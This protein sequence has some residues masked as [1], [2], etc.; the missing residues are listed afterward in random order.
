MNA[1]KTLFAQLMD[2]VPWSTFTRL[3]T[4]YDGD[5]RVRS[6]SC[7]EQYRAMAFAQ[8]T[9][10]ESLRDIE[11][12][13]SAQATKLYAMGF[14]EPVRRSTLA[15]ANEA[16]N[17][18]I[19]AELAQR[20]I[21]QARKLYADEDLG[22]DLKN[23]VYAL[24][25]TTIDLCLSVFPWAHFR[26]TKSAVKMHTLL[27]L[28]GNI[29][30][31][32]HISDGKL[33]DV[34]ALDLL[35]PEPG[36]IYVMDRAYVDFARL[37]ALHQAGAF[38]VTRA[39]SNMDAR[40]VY[41]APSDRAAGIICDQTIAL[42]G[43]QTSRHYPEHL[44]RVRFKDPETGK[45]LV[46]LTNQR[47]LPAAT[48]CALY[49]SRWQVELFFKWIKQHLRIK[50]FYGTSENAVKTQ[51]WIAVSVYVLVAI[52]KKRLELDASL[53]TLLQI[54]SITLFE[55]MPILQALSQDQRTSEQPV[56]DNQLNLFAR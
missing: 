2:F 39:K 26:T 51:I 17:W 21:A 9:Y 52:V 49:K 44:R 54:L 20:L 53:Y 19:Y 27:D 55:K 13:L 33:H 7:G 36:A 23:S 40:R 10:R 14:R 8:L 43:V 32:I 11:T 35:M 22:L 1:G 24:D 48:I 38:F 56:V 28:R 15:D 34:H 5:I 29:P 47:T 41:S 6:L 45:S 3:V 4:R 37:H 25:S 16:R 31:F 42:S 12:C 50:K 18:C 30:S 46:F